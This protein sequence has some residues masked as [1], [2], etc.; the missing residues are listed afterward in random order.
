MNT[1]GA[2]FISQGG[3]SKNL[4]N[5]VE[6]IASV[7]CI[8]ANNLPTFCLEVD[9]VGENTSNGTI[10]DRLSPPFFNL[11]GSVPSRGLT[12]LTSLMMKQILA[13]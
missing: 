12:C 9:V 10:S 7:V 3:Y 8:L 5:G 6:S 2:F 1:A 4:V 13:G 11:Q